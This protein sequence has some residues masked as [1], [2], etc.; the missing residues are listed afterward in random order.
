MFFFPF[1]ISIKHINSFGF[2][3]ILDFL[4]ELIIGFIYTWKIGAP[5]VVTVF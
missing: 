1:T 2:W 4:V 5:W 3:V